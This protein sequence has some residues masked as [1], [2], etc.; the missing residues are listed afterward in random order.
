MPTVA[1]LWHHALYAF[2]AQNKTN[3]SNSD[4]VTCCRTAVPPEDVAQVLAAQAARLLSFAHINVLGNHTEGLLNLMAQ[5][6]TKQNYTSIFKMM[7][8]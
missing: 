2:K 8:L 4:S 3:S 6:I 1:L 5:T 7:G